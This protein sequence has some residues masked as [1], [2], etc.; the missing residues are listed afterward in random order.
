LTNFYSHDKQPQFTLSFFNLEVTMATPR[1]V[2]LGPQGSG[3]GTHGEYLASRLSIP[4]ISTGNL[5]R[6]EISE[7]SELGKSI[8]AKMQ[9]G[10]YMTDDIMEP[11]LAQRLR[12][13]D[14]R[15]GWILD[16]YPRRETQVATLD[17]I[18]PPT[19]VIALELDDESAVQRLAGRWVCDQGH[20]WHIEH[21]WPADGLCAFDGSPLTQRSDDTEVAIR[22]RLAQYREETEPLIKQYKQRGIV[23]HVTA[24]IPISAVQKLLLLPEFWPLISEGLP[25]TRTV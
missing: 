25:A 1:I 2:M 3:K 10:S 4:H 19:A 17:R 11:L 14:C 21:R 24:A 13:P 7:Q 8:Q 9:A 23:L 20:P 15:S 6:D 22:K 16:G 18:V 12:Q 5:L